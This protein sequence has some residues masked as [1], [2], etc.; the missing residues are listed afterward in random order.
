MRWVFYSNAMEKIA[1]QKWKING[2]QKKKLNEST[3]QI[4]ELANSIDSF[5]I[6]FAFFLSCLRQT[7]EDEGKNSFSE[8]NDVAVRERSKTRMNVIDNAT[9]SHWNKSKQ[10]ESIRNEIDLMKNKAENK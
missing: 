9:D 6:I 1:I 4:W 2:T 8:W 5:W 3:Q 10:A 7:S